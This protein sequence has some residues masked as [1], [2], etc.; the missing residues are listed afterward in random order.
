MSLNAVLMPDSSSWI[1][2][3]VD[4]C[5][6]GGFCCMVDATRTRYALEEKGP[7]N[8]LEIFNL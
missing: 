1:Q 3:S 8:P 5:P 6:L 7:L 2:F 4:N